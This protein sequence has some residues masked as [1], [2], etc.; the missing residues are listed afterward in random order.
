ML[1]YQ[2]QQVP[3]NFVVY[4]LLYK[5]T[6]KLYSCLYHWYYMPQNLYK[7]LIHGLE[8]IVYLVLQ[9]CLFREEAQE[10]LNKKFNM[11]QG[12]SFVQSLA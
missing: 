3:V 7:I 5:E 1:P 12:T 6:T 2:M 9:I 4:R 10:A 8:I 11:L